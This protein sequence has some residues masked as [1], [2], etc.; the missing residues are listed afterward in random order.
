[1]LKSPGLVRSNDILMRYALCFLLAS[2]GLLSHSLAAPGDTIRIQSHQET[3][4]SWNNNYLDTVQFPTTGNFQKVLMHCFLGCPTIGCSEWDYKSNIEIWEDVNGTTQR[5]EIGRIITPYSGNRNYGWFHEYVIDVTDYLP[6]LTGEKTV[7]A[8]YGGFQDGFTMTVYFDFIEGTPPRDVL[9]VS[10]VYRSGPG[11]FLYGDASD[12]IE[13]HL[14]PTNISLTPQTQDATFRLVATGHGFGNN[15]QNGNPDNCAEFC[16]KYYTLQ[17]NGLVQAQ[18]TVWKDD[19]G[20]EPYFAQTGTWVYNRAGWC[21]G[22][23][24]MIFDDRLTSDVT[25]SGNLTLNVDW[26]PY[27]YTGGSGFPIHYWIE[28]QLIEYGDFNFERDAE[29]TLIE[30]PT[31]YDRMSRFNPTCFSP[32]VTV[33]NNG[34]ETITSL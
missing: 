34:S 18:N 31:T 20:S 5:T 23:E 15:A 24:A 21:P 6:L 22:S 9:R 19:C 28:A 14:T 8:Y 3:H 29:I 17:L 32:K 30:R 26:E 12:P 33:R 25:P 10:Q 1:M 13:D 16:P 4:W 7:N 2:C 11:G 27:T